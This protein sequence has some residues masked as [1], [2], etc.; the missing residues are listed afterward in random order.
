LVEVKQLHI[1]P[2]S[3][4]TKVMRELRQLKDLRFENVNTFIG[5]FI[6]QN[7]PALIF[8]YGQRGSLEDILKKEEIKLDW[9]FKWSMLNDLVRVYIISSF[10]FFL[11]K[12]KQNF[13]S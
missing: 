5:I 12:I 1:G 8:D 13:I 2:L 7:A 4:R 9:N 10:F 11:I 6:D 3:L